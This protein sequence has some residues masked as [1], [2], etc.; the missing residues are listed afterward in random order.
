M[1][2]VCPH[3]MNVVTI[4]LNKHLGDLWNWVQERQAVLF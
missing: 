2:D 4:L 1:W 3:H